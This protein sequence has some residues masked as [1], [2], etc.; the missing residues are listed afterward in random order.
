[1][2]R[3]LAV[4]VLVFFVS[5]TFAIRPH[6]DSTTRH[7][8]TKV[9][10]LHREGRRNSLRLECHSRASKIVHMPKISAHRERHRYSVTFVIGRAGGVAVWQVRQVVS[11]HLLIVLEPTTGK[12]NR[13]SRLNRNGV[14]I[15]DRP[16]TDD[17]ASL[18]VLYQLFAWG[19]V[20]DADRTLFNQA[21]KPLP[22]KRIAIGRSVMKLVHAIGTW[23][24]RKLDTDRLVLVL[25]RVGANA[26]KPVI[27][28]AHLLRPGP[29]HDLW[30]LVR[31]AKRG[32]IG[33]SVLWIGGVKI[34]LA[35]DPRVAS[36]LAFRRLFQYQDIGAKF[37]RGDR[38]GEASRTEADHDDVRRFVPE[39]R[40]R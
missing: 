38:G 25:L 17:F 13:L 23:Q 33:L 19:F 14:S 6:R 28:L 36:L 16:D 9:E 26:G 11:D 10:R 21:F 15:A 8:L 34:A 18:A 20:E 1:M 4:P 12:H 40:Q 37:V 31:A 35:G 29:D 32:Q 39:F 2:Q 24:F 3:H 27:V 30:H 22:G 7:L 5:E